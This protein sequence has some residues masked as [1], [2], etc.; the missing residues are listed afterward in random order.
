MSALATG[1]PAAGAADDASADVLVFDASG[2]MWGQLKGGENKIVV[3]REVMADFFKRRD[4]DTPL[5]V[6]A[7]GHRRRGDCKDIEVIAASG[8]HDAGRLSSQLAAINPRGMTPIAD[9]LRQAAAQIPRT[10]ERSNIILVTDGLETCDADPCAVAAELAASGHQ[11]RAHVVGFGLTEKEASALSCVT[12]QTGGLLLRPQS[13]AELA[14]ALDQ[15]AE[16]EPA[17]EPVVEEAFFDIGDKAET[18]HTYRISYQGTAA[19][20]DYAGFTPRGEDSPTVGPSFNTIGGGATA[21]N[22][23]SVRAPLEPGDYD[24]ILFSSTGRKIIARQPIEVVPAANGFDPVGSVPPG[25]RFVFT[26]RGPN[27]VGQRVVIA[28]AGDDPGTYDKSAWGYPLSG[29]GKMGLKAPDEPGMYQ[30][31]YLSANGKSVMFH[32]DFGVGVPYEDKDLTTSAALAEQAAIATRA[33]PGQDA[34]PRVRATFRIPAGFPKTP[35]WWSA[36]PLDADATPDAWAL[37]EAQVVG[38]GSFEPGRY[39]VTAVGPGE[40]EFRKTVEIAPGQS[41]EFVLD[42]VPEPDGDSEPTPVRKPAARPAPA[43][44][45]AASPQAAMKALGGKPVKSKALSREQMDT[46]LSTRDEK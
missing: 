42:L 18:G 1:A 11:I 45:G 10:A 41:N 4:V 35:V 43:G 32:R 3:A 23:F 24:L 31:R 7:Y 38:Q 40:V 21:N 5:A 46:L 36:V 39:E 34:L 19:N 27:Q 30:L 20:T 17:P 12:E 9:S 26:W 33:A 44:G 28:R 16:D 14:A 2:S 6:I 37:P 8:K 15:I 29:K 13:G 25:K 22:P